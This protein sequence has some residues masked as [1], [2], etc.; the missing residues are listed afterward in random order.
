M[1]A[2]L[3]LPR[4]RA[5]AVEEKQSR[6][7]A[8]LD[9]AERVFVLHTGRLANMIEVAHAA[10]LAKG[11]VYL[12]FP[13]KEEL[14][15][16]LHER[17]VGDFFH[18]LFARLAKSQPLSIEDMLALTWRYMLAP[19]AFLPLAA[20][21]QGMMEK[22]IPPET[23]IQ[24]HLRIGEWVARAGAGIERHFPALGAGQGAVLLMRSY[25]LILGLWQLMQPGCLPEAVRRKP[26][27]ELFNRE[28]PA[29]L[30]QALRAL[31]SGHLGAAGARA[32]PRSRARKTQR[33]KR[34]SR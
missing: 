3:A 8:I 9:A 6:R 17:H 2:A 11:T 33:K 21:C 24:F 12:Y 10:G 5:I 29:E 4:Q 18:A 27:F 15:L 31:W 19:P 30:E 7:Q 1:S 13:S 16:A 25:A 14:L 32:S 28:Y 26:G 23:R 22:S 34:G 20:L